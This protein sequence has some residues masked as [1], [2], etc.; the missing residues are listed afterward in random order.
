MLGNEAGRGAFK[1]PPAGAA[2]FKFVVYG[3][4][5]SRH[6]MHQRVIDAMVKTEPDFVIHTGDLVADGLDTA[7]WPRFFSIERELLRKTV[8]FPV[9]GNHERNSPHY[10]E[11]FDMKKPYYS[12][13][14]GTAHF[15]L[16]DTGIAQSE[17]DEQARWFEA[18]LE[19]AAKADFRFV[20]FHHPPYTA[21]KRRQGDGGRP[22]GLVPLMEKHKVQAVFSGHD[23]NYQRHFQNGIH[24]V[25]T[26]G[27]GAPLYPVD[28]PIEG[29]TKKVVSTEHYVQM[30]VN[31]AAARME[32]VA[33]DGSLIEGVEIR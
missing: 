31:G 23:H 14:W 22:R 2:E 27:G 20:I 11:F 3:D 17:W 13:D 16:L 7:Q 24:Y 26:G 4:T 6:D 10:F 15:S 8:F 21:V 30:R 25:V 33:L 1:T 9:L 29:M 18:D 12:F 32:A 28:A 5:R 19:R